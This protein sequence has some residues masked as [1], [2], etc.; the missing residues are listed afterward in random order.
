MSRQQSGH[1]VCHTSKR[2][3]VKV[4]HCWHTVTNWSQNCNSFE[5]SLLKSVLELF[6]L[7]LAV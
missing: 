3:K 4:V 7:L 2:N 5:F 6:L 1:R